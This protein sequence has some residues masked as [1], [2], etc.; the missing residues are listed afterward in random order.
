M[1]SLSAWL[2]LLPAW[3]LG[4]VKE[5]AKNELSNMPRG[6][7]ENFSLSSFGSPRA[8]LGLQSTVPAKPCL[9][10]RSEYLPKPRVLKAWSEPHG[11]TERGGGTFK[12][13]GPMEAL[14]SQQGSLGGIVGQ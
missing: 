5:H 12:M 7:R 11:T 8:S 13:W 2:G 3:Q 1:H 9:Q 6:S 4:S 14:R 10:F